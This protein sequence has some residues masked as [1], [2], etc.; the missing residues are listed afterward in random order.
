[1]MAAGVGVGVGKLAT[2]L[3]INPIIIVVMIAEEDIVD[4][5]GIKT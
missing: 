1:M 2:A 3:R 4:I 5:A